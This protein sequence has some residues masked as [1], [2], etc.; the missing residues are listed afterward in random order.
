MKKLLFLFVWVIS[1]FPA[2]A[3]STDSVQIRRIYDFALTRAECYENLRYLCKRIGH[4]LSGSPQAEEAVRWGKKVM[5]SYGFDRV[6]LQEVKV[7]LWVRSEREKAWVTID[8]GKGAS[9]HTQDLRITTLGGSV[10]TEGVLSAEVVEVQNFEELEKAGKTL[11][12][13]IVF[14]NR[15]IDPTFINTFSAYGGCVN[16]RVE[17]A[18]QAARYGAVAV[19]VRS[20]THLHDD[21]PHTGTL[22]YRDSVTRIPGV[23]LSTLSADALHDLLQS[24]QTVKVSLDLGCYT[25]EDVLSYNVIG[26]LTGT[27]YPDRIIVV[28]AHLDSWDLGEGAHDDGAGVVQSIE[29]LRIF[30]KL[31]IRPRHTLRAVLYMNEENGNRGG[32]LY[33]EKAGESGQSH[34][35][36]I[37]S[38]RGGFAPRG[39]TMDAPDALFPTFLSW[40]KVLEAYELH[41][42]EKG[43]AGVDISP[44]KKVFPGIFL[45]GFVP[46]SQ[47]YFDYHHAET[48]VFEAVNKRELELG[49]A[50]MAAVV[51]LIDNRLP[52]TNP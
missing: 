32:K 14:F 1:G 13:K 19:L 2:F 6:W 52:V 39:F 51:Y 9:K 46:D 17:G 33:A 37:E 45:L 35:A 7:P 25:G 24:G 40:A 10:G 20:V 30:Q 12:G 42:F 3:Q 11:E 4:R 48:D 28:G 27:H 36:A 26:E 38:D 22:V 23:A 50:A 29:V 47:R 49:A 16:Q 21:H 5:E 34:I 18:V 43:Y 41:I 8:P 15:P 44:L 31:G